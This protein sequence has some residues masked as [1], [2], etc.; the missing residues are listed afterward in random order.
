MEPKKL[1]ANE[2]GEY[3]CPC[4]G[5][6]LQFIEGQPVSIIN[7][8]LNMEDVDGK[9]YCKECS[10]IFRRL[11][12]T[13]YYQRYDVDIESIQESVGLTKNVEEFTPVKLDPDAPE[14]C[15]CPI[16]N[17][18]LQFIAGK[19]IQI[20]D[21]KFNMEDAEGRF[22]CEACHS[23]FRRLLN[24]DYYQY[25]EVEKKNIAD[26]DPI[27]LDINHPEKCYCPICATKLELIEGRPVQIIGGKLNMKDTEAHFRC[28]K[29][30][31]VYRRLVN[32]EYYQW[33]EE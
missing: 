27:K 15:S 21:G 32:T 26:L 17:H 24:T 12:N 13:E 4:C 3:K 16:C 20:V 14:G 10:S 18:K 7:G 30:Q 31:G 29:C 9:Y 1:V 33:Y 25:Y 11:L 6:I 8:K 22:Y 19:P 28:P 2:K 23:E 5:A